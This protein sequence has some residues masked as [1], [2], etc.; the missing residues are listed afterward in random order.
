MK[1]DKREPCTA[2]SRSRLPCKYRS[3][4]PS[5]HR[6]KRKATSGDG[7]T[8]ALLERLRAHETTLQHAGVPFQ[9]FD[10]LSTSGPGHGAADR[11]GGIGHGVVERSSSGRDSHH[12]SHSHSRRSHAQ[13]QQESS[14]Q[15]SLPYRD[16]Q[17]TVGHTAMAEA[18]PIPARQ[19]SQQ[20]EQQ[21]KSHRGVL[22]SEDGGKR[23]Y[24]HGF[25]GIMGQEV[26]R[27]LPP[28]ASFSYNKKKD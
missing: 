9:R 28:Q 19:S 18:P 14:S 20:E 8:E 16:S 26:S 3:T 4:P 7:Y 15:E 23:Y 5:Q 13:Q 17:R 6:R 27:P 10:D 11:D 25:I 21:S 24:E 22:L 12:S 1:C 2:C